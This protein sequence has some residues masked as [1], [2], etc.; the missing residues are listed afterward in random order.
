MAIVLFDPADRESFFP[1]T[2]TRAVAAFRMGMLTIQQR[3]QLWSNQP[4]FILT[5]HY[6]QSLYPV[7]EQGTHIWIDATVL[8]DEALL[9]QILQLQHGQAVQDAQGIVACCIESDE[10][11]F[12]LAEVSPRLTYIHTWQHP[13]NRLMYAWDLFKCNDEWARKDFGLLTAGS[14]PPSLSHTNQ[15]IRPDLVYVEEG[16]EV[17]F[18]TLNAATGPIYIARN[19]VIMEGSFLRGPL[20]I[21]EGTVVKMGAKIYGATTI[22][23]R[24]TVGGEIKNAIIMG[25]SNKAHDGYLGDAVIGEWCNLGAGTSN[26][27]VKNTGGEVKIWHHS[28]GKFVLAG[29]KCGMIMGDYTRTAINTAINTGTIIG[30]C[31]NVFGDGLT[32]KVL[33]PFTWGSKGI[34]RYE[35]EKALQDVNNWKKMKHSELTVQET[36][37]LKHVFEHIK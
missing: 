16:A 10:G 36:E 32:P 2:Q 19:A 7:I 12:S 4:V 30:T 23:P 26:S 31:C 33:A 27:N 13:V 14:I 37:V 1:L 22:G 35:F 15:V 24:C 20:Y 34:T 3:W 21:G 8:P 5:A 25:N 9:Q 17:E 6:L 29:F 11:P 28:T 18:A